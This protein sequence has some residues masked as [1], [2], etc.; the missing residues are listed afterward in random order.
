MTLDIGI[1]REIINDISV[2][3]QKKKDFNTVSIVLLN[4]LIDDFSELKSTIDAQNKKT[5]FLYNPLFDIPI[6]EPIHS[7]ILAKLLNP[8]AKHG[9][10]GLFLYTFLEQIGIKE[11][12][13]GS[14]RVT[15]EL[16]RIDILL[17]RDNPLSIVIV[18]NKSNNAQDQPNQLYRYWYQEI[19]KRKDD[20]IY[21]EENFQILYLCSSESKTPD[22]NSITIPSELKLCEDKRLPDTMPMDYKLVNFNPDIVRWLTTSLK[23]LDISNHRLSEFINLYIELWR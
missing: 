3:N 20:L 21:P 22:E 1:A 10:G 14:W 8:Y 9:Q 12:T 16:G 7:K 19:F 13:S 4:E 18:E 11:P 5:S 17:V 2:L 6:Q 15:A 23:K